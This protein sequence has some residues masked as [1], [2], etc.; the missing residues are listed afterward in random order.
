MQEQLIASM[1]VGP[2]WIVASRRWVV[3]ATADWEYVVYWRRFRFN[4]LLFFGGLWMAAWSSEVLADCNTNVIL[5]VHLCF[6]CFLW[7]C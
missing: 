5:Y 7:R 2:V 3:A 1:P 6:A 4:T